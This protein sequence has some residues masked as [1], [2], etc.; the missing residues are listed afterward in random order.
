M[1]EAEGPLPDMTDTPAA[2]AT[3]IGIGLD[4]VTLDP[5][6]M[7]TAI[8]TTAAMTH[9]GVNQDHSTNIHATTS[10][11]IEVPATTATILIHPTTDIPGMP[12]ETSA[13]CT[14]DPENTSTNQPEDHHHLHGK[15]LTGNINKS[16]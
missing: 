8:G 14:I 3:D 7:S 10:H 15:V 11:A 12:P 16:Q 1:T 2:H 6:L 9:V 4:T 5:D 13:D